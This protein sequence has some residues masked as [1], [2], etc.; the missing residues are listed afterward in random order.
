[1]YFKQGHLKFLNSHL[2]D[3]YDDLDKDV[4]V[5][6]LLPLPDGPPELECEIV[7]ID[8]KFPR[9]RDQFLV[10]CA[11]TLHP[12]SSPKTCSPSSCPACFTVEYYYCP[13]SPEYIVLAKRFYAAVAQNW[14]IGDR[15]RTFYQEGWFNGVIKDRRPQSAKY[16]DSRWGSLVVTWDSDG[17]E[18][19]D[20][21][22]WEIERPSKRTTADRDFEVLWDKTL[23]D[24]RPTHQ[25]VLDEEVITALAAL[26]TATISEDFAKLF[27]LPVSLEDYPDYPQMVPVPM[28]LSLIMR[29]LQGHFYRDIAGV[30]ADVQQILIACKLFNKANSDIVKNAKKLVATLQEG[31]VA[32][33]GAKPWFLHNERSLRG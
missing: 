24:C 2:H 25:Q 4:V 11:L 12:T 21:N 28:S 33:V 16:P 27:L 19:K 3:V 8:F 30:F 6:T 26:V 13:D 10:Y 29:R 17:S 22:L 31:I 14:K 20:L 23:V 5:G 32:I 9:C 18:D 15:F 7:A 1:M